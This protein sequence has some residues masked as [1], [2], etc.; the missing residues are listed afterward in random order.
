M[1][2]FMFLPKIIYL[3]ISLLA[4]F[5]IF[6]L[7]RNYQITYDVSQQT[8]LNLNEREIV[9]ISKIINSNANSFGKAHN[10]KTI[11]NHPGYNDSSKNYKMINFGYCD[12]SQCLI[13]SNEFKKS[14]F[15]LIFYRNRIFPFLYDDKEFF[16]IKNSYE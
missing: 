11:D 2:N 7:N 13:L 10:F 8:L 12:F 14:E 1:K 3:C 9:E 16:E 15:N 4:I 6:I 5:L